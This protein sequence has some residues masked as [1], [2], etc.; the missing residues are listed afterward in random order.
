[1]KHTAAHAKPIRARSRGPSRRIAAGRPP[2]GPADIAAARREEPHSMA[3][4]ESLCDRR[5]AAQAQPVAQEQD[6]GRRKPR[7]GG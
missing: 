5:D 4:F 6:G 2:T 3:S 1:M 7:R